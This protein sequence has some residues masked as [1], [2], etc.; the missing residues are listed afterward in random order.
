MI[1]AG[2]GDLSSLNEQL[3]LRFGTVIGGASSRRRINNPLDDVLRADEI[4]GDEIGPERRDL[5]HESEPDGKS[6]VGSRHLQRAIV[7][8]SHPGDTYQS[9]RQSD[10]PGVAAL[11]C[12]RLSGNGG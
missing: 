1:G 5:A 10:K 6:G 8:E 12:P 2:I 11:G 9:R 7:I 4:S 3:T